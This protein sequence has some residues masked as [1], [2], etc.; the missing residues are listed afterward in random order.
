MCGIIGM[1]A[2][3]N[4]NVIPFLMEG[5]KR[6]EYRG[7]DSSGIAA[8]APNG[9]LL[10]RRS[11]GKLLCLEQRIEHSPIQGNTGIGHTRW[12][13]HGRPTRNNAHPH[14][15][16]A[17]AVVHNGIIENFHE[18][19]A[20]L[21][22]GGRT[23][24][25]DTDTE[26]IPHLITQFLEQGLTPDDAVL[27]TLELLSGT[28]ALAILFSGKEQFIIA[29]R[30]GLPLAIG[31]GNGEMFIGSDAIAL[32]P[33]TSRISYLKDGD[34]AKICNTG[35]IVRDS[36][37][38]LVTREICKSEHS[39]NVSEKDGY[40]DYTLKEIY[41]QPVVLKN[42]FL[43]YTQSPTNSIV[44]PKTPFKLANIKQI[45][46]SACGTSYYAGMIGK[47]WLEKFA[48]LP[49]SLDIASEFRYRDTP[50]SKGGL[51]LFIS[52]SGETADTL[53]ALQFAK[54]HKQHIMSI[55][56][57][58]ESTIARASD[59]AFSTFSGAEISV[60]STKAFTSQLLVL[61]CLSL[62][63]AKINKTMKTEEIQ[64]SAAELANL[65]A[66]IVDVLD[67]EAA[68]TSLAQ[69]IMHAQ[70]ILYMGRGTCYPVA[71]EGALKMKELTYI[72]AEGIAAGELKHGS[73][74]LIDEQT[75]VIA[76]APSDALFEKTCSNIQEISARGGKVIVFCSAEGAKKMT[77]IAWKIIILPE[78][79]A[80]LIPFLYTVPL[81][82]LAYH[83][84]VARGNNV[85]QPRNLAKSVTVE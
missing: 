18:L 47:Y 75:P 14:G 71:L 73:I 44:L 27:K 74:A 9:T 26:V 51:S 23:L 49:V 46:I 48:K 64:R 12:A 2:S 68:I 41:E 83:V 42:A 38:I 39:D 59:I 21:I 20:H 55:V 40:A 34:V 28:F 1:A 3:A 36:N 17:V 63:F 50:L 62:E 24:T 16:R 61:A 33:L 30:R 31:H 32:A 78:T 43:K 58:Q 69:Q 45:T 35:V 19:R 6:L 57:V 66:L 5:L 70:T 29:A 52:Q 84:A 11:E 56:N 77:T 60:A 80:L 76:L 54:T 15:T 79:D 25:S 8:L 65:P 53:A 67:N 13:T 22:S 72:H 4:T 81:Q 85:D 10:R 37:N 7:Y 82:L